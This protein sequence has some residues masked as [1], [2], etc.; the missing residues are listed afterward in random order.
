M[1]GFSTP[2]RLLL[3]LLSLVLPAQNVPPP[4]Q[5]TSRGGSTQVISPVAAVTWVTREGNY[6]E[7]DLIVVWRGLEFAAIGVAYTAKT[8]CSGT[9]VSKRDAPTKNQRRHG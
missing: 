9:F 3:L 8:V 5:T 6:S 7:I 1:P 2:G 4:P